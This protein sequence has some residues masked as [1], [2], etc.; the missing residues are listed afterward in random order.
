MEF[1]TSLFAGLLLWPWW[2]LGLFFVLCLIDAVLVENDSEGWATAMLLI[3][4]F[5]LS[6]MFGSTN[7]FVFIWNNLGGFLLYLL[8]YAGIGG[9]WSVFKWYLFLLKER[10]HVL[11]VTKQFGTKAQRPESS[12]ARNN[13]SKITGWISHWP[14]SIIGTFFG[15]FLLRLWNYVYKI[16]GN[17]YNSISD[18][19]FADFG[20]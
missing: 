13:K 11:L 3:G 2:G 15:D 14:L 20:K 16:F 9:V 8:V 17:V 12:Y 5:S 7:P 4:I 1:L 6:W 10:D 18:A 19:V